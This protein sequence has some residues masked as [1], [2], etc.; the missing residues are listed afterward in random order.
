MIP[1]A[2]KDRDQGRSGTS[3]LEIR[4][5]E[6]RCRIW[7]GG[8]WQAEEER[9]GLIGALQAA[10]GKSYRALLQQACRAL[11]ARGTQAAYGPVDGS[12][13]RRYRLS[14]ENAGL[15]PLPMEPWNP[16][17][18]AR[19]M[20]ACGFAPAA[21]YRSAMA[22]L[23]EREEP[24]LTA[25]PDLPWRDRVRLRGL[26][27]ADWRRNLARVHGLAMEAFRRSLLFDPL[28]LESFLAL[29]ETQRRLMTA[30]FC[31]LAEEGDELAGFLFAFPLA[32]W[33]ESGSGTLVVKSL[34]VKRGRAYA[35]LGRH[36]VRIVERRARAAGLTRVVHALMREGGHSD[37]FSRR[38]AKPFRRYALYRR[39]LP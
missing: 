20:E 21:L 27:P 1:I 7:W 17:S 30:D 34:A 8:A 25:R 12:I 22:D 11:A 19:W 33:P 4:A 3:S 18:H 26:E 32:G 39:S 36:L 14:I 15:P 35:G 10:D 38:S 24:G 29:Y 37:A 2:G 5:G 13:W 16:P 23:S 28:P 9:P 6:G 31:L